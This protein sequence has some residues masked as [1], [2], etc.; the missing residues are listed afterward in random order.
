[1]SQH[2][3]D[4][5][6][7]L[8]LAWLAGWLEGEGTFITCPPNHRYPGG[9]VTIAAAST[10]HDT[11]ERARAIAGVGSI[12]DRKKQADHHKQAWTWTVCRREEVLWLARQLYPFM[13]TRRRKAI[14]QQLASPEHGRPRHK[15]HPC[16][17]A[18]SYSRGCRCAPCTKANT[19]RCRI[20]RMRSAKE[21]A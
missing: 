4:P 11:L 12:T 2:T 1:M 3:R 18:A 21:N 14:E 6:A 19:D 8:S 15:K 10:D 5:I 7:P 17:T 16:G 20:Y 9:F 13:G